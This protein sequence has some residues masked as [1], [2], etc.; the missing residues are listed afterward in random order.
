LATPLGK[1]ILVL[2]TD[3]ISSSKTGTNTEL[4]KEN[5][6]SASLEELTEE[7]RQDYLVA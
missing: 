5:I 2:E 1:K 7:E 6:I 4:N 3:P